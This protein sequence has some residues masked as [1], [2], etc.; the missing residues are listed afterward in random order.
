MEYQRTTFLSFC[1][2]FRCSPVSHCCNMVPRLWA[3]LAAHLPLLLP[4]PTTT[5]WLFPSSI[6]LFINFSRTL[7][8]CCNGKF[9]SSTTNTLAYVVKQANTTAENLRN[10][11]DYL[12]AAKLIGVDQVFLPSDMMAKIDE[13]QTKINSSAATLAD[14]TVKNSDSTQ[15]VLDNM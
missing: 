12:V 11:L 5:L 13:V 4:L 14:E 1:R 2:F 3:L 9:H 7:H 8:H 10:V 15:E 6:C